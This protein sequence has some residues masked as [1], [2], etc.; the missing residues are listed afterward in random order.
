M[1]LMYENMKVAY[2]TLNFLEECLMYF[3]ERTL[4]ETVVL[5][6]RPIYSDEHRKNLSENVCVVAN[7]AAYMCTQKT[8]EL[9]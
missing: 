3:G 9:L 8:L 2:K 7:R 5:D 4:D 6:V 1:R